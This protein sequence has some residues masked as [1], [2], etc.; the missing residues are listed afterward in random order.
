MYSG[1]LSQQA[2]GKGTCTQ[3]PAHSEVQGWGVGEQE[4]GKGWD[5]E[6]HSRHPYL[7]RCN[8]AS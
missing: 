6:G 7:L 4:W 5:Q 1:Q 8:L 3:G 2:P